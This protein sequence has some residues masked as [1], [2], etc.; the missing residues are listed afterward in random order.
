MTFGAPAAAAT[1]WMKKHWKGTHT[2][3]RQYFVL[4][5]DGSLSYSD[6]EGAPAKGVV[7]AGSI[8]SASAGDAAAKI[9][10]SCSHE[11]HTGLMVLECADGADAFRW[12]QALDAAA[13]PQAAAPVPEGPREV[14]FFGAAEP[15]P[16]PAPADA[17][18]GGLFGAAA[19]APAPEAP[20]EMDFFGGAAEPAAVPA[21]VA[22]AAMGDL[23]GAAAPAAAPAPEPPREIFSAP[24][25]PAQDAAALDPSNL[26]A[27]FGAPPPKA[28]AQS[29]P[30]DMLAAF[31]PPP[32]AEAPAAEV[33]LGEIEVDEDGDETAFI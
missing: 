20:R 3:H 17:V 22:D 24:A 18:V 9:Q 8:H 32:Q 23:F 30:A 21:P 15:A 27:A 10:V 26:L 2:H 4:G 11:G 7:A 6:Q 33:E 12:M 1:G 25:A 29:S 16:A 14:D 28:A 5:T 13:T 19:P 31:A